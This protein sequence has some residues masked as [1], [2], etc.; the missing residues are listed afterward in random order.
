MRVLHL[1]DLHICLSG[2]RAEECR[3]IIDWIPPNAREVKPDVIV[4]CGDIFERRST[5][6][7]R[8]F[9]AEFLR[10]LSDVAPVYLINGNHDDK[11]DLRLFRKEYGWS[12]PIEVVLEPAVLSLGGLRMAFLPWPEFGLLA[13]ASATAS[14]ATRRELARSALIDILQGFRTNPGIAPGKPSLLITH[15]SVTGA[16]MDSGQPVSGGEG[17]S[18]SVDDLLQS[19]TAG[20]ALGHIHLR[21]QM[22]CFDGRQVHYAGAPFRS[23][24]GEAKGTKGGLIWDWDG[25]TWKV[26]PWD[27]PARNMVL[28]E[29]TWIAP[30]E[31]AVLEPNPGPLATDEDVRDADVRLRI[32]FPAEFREAMRVA[33]TPALDSLRAA[34]HYVTVEER[35]TIISR[36]R[37]VEITAARMTIEK[38]RAW[39]QAVGTDIPDGAEVKLGILEAGVMQ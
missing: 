11:N 24:F 2:P 25:K 7:E 26:M 9:L 37:C 15:L 4:I 10:A 34:A 30:E 33:M 28:L 39:A 20:I 6:Q 19:G 1:A 14:I 23:S 8:I 3:R 5:P 17:I 22:R 16:S 12:M 21:Q 36:T 29:H 32:T 13:K 38:L 18:L 31:G 27:T 35:P